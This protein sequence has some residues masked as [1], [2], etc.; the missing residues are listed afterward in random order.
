MDTLA[1]MVARHSESLTDESTRNA[2]K[3]VMEEQSEYELPGLRLE[4]ACVS[5][6]PVWRERVLGRVEVALA[7][8]NDEV[9]MDAL[10]A[11]RVLSEGLA[12]DTEAADVAKQGLMGLLRA[13]SHKVLWRNMVVP[14]ATMST[15]ADVVG[16][17]P[18]T[19]AGDVERS[20]L[21]GLARLIGETAIQGV[22]A[23]KH[24]MDGAGKEVWMKLLVRRTAARLAY[25]LF[26]HCYQGRGG[27]VP[28]EIAAW[29]E[30]CRSDDEFAEVRNQWIGSGS[31]I[32]GPAATGR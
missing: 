11:I 19:F 22:G 15:L 13:A 25:R 6:F 28:K 21:L 31:G 16:R 32:S 18:G 17:H 26:E 1:A 27:A 10:R 9:V 24:K 8:T 30:V 2:V 7:S 29:E 23:A 3:R 12:T 14:S 5:L 20:V 4:M